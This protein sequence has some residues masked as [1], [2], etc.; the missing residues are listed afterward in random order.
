MFSIFSRF[1]GTAQADGLHAA[2]QPFGRL[3]R[4][5]A[6]APLADVL[7]G[8]AN[9]IDGIGRIEA[10]AGDADRRVDEGDLPFGKLAV[11]GRTGHLDHLADYQSVGG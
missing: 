2:N 4:D 8:F 1:H 3:Q 7:L 5:G 6:N 11:H 10:L 9:D